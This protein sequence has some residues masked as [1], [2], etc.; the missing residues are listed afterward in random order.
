[1]RVFRGMPWPVR[2][3][4]D[5]PRRTTDYASTRTNLALMETINILARA[6]G[7]AERAGYP[8]AC[9]PYYF[10]AKA[11]VGP[12]EEV[13]GGTP[14]FVACFREGDGRTARHGP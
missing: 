7:T 12:H 10:R 3:G 14:Y 2:F 6:G 5:T 9:L 8:L 11:L 4:Q 1:M 13:G